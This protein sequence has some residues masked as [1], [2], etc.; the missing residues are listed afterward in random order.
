MVV[1]ARCTYKLCA[2]QGWK[3]YSGAAGEKKENVKNGRA[4]KGRQSK[5]KDEEGERSYSWSETSKKQVR[6]SVHIVLNS[7]RKEPIGTK[8]VLLTKTPKN[9][10]PNEAGD[11]LGSEAVNVTRPNPSSLLT[12]H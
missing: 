12:Q 8:H 1:L 10:W 9:C 4:C 11:K 5:K 3:L 6:A 7:K 2:P